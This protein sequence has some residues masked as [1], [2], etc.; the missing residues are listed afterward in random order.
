MRVN[1]N[2]SRNLAC[3]LKSTRHPSL[4]TRPR[5]HSYSNAVNPWNW[6]KNHSRNTKRCQ[7]EHMRGRR[8]KS[9][10]NSVYVLT[11]ISP[12]TWWVCSEKNHL[13]AIGTR[14]PRAFRYGSS[15]VDRLQPAT[16]KNHT[17]S[18]KNRQSRW[19]AHRGS[20]TTSHCRL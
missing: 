10:Q 8:L 7:Q 6:V 17:H 15:R 9:D 14:N 19:P 18:N 12:N 5:P 16:S 20:K 4:L 11:G 3:I 1:Q 13:S 2:F